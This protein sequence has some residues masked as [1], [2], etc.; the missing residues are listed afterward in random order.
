MRTLGFQIAHSPVSVPVP[1]LNVGDPV[2]AEGNDVES[3]ALADA[4]EEAENDVGTELTADVLL[5]K[6][7][8]AEGGADDSAE[9]TEADTVDS[10]ADTED[11]AEEGMVDSDTETEEGGTRETDAEDATEEGA[12]ELSEVS[13]ELRPGVALGKALDT[14]LL[15]WLLSGEP[16]GAASTRVASWMRPYATRRPAESFMVSDA[17]R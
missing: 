1:V 14:A 8:A 11:A 15:S 2:G 5:I 7:D 9:D 13:T 4:A 16:E 10:D 12:T 3:V 6:E 17:N